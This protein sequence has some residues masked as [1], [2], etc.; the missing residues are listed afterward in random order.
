MARRL[1][2]ATTNPHKVEEFRGLLAGL[3]Y[4]LVSLTDLGIAA[5]VEETGTTFAENAVIK[6]VAY[7]EMSGLPALADDSGL[8]VD[9][10]DGAPGLYSARWAGPEVTYAVR[11]RL[12]VER[13]A[14][15]PDERRGARYLCAIA[16][17]EPPPRGLF[18]VVEGRLEGRIADAP[19]GEGGFG[20]DPIFLV[21]E[22]GRTVGQMSA[23]EKSRIS[24]RAR[25]AWAARPLLERLAHAG[26]GE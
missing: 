1:L 21:P 12:I 17:A 24:H 16:I 14:G 26:D 23:D 10:L 5:D 6:A 4:E 18:G 2:I 25:A 7:A 20:Y 3:P 11:N 22:D 13:L 9:A 19:A 8:E 15:L